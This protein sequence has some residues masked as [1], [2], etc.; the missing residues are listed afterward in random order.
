MKLLMLNPSQIVP[1]FED[2]K[3]DDSLVNL[4]ENNGP[5]ILPPIPIYELPNEL[6]GK[7]QFILADGHHRRDG[8]VKAETEISCVWYGPNEEILIEE[9]GLASFY[10]LGVEKEYRYLILKYNER[11]FQGP[12]LPTNFFS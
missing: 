1:L 8:A 12:P 5:K 7:H 6:K 3:A 9:H 2:I 11:M 10:Y 4:I